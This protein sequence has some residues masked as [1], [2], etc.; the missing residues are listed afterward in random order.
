MLSFIR[1]RRRARQGKLVTEIGQAALGFS[2]GYQSL[3][4]APPPFKPRGR[5]HSTRFQEWL[6]Q[7]DGWAGIHHHG[8]TEYQAGRRRG[9]SS[10]DFRG[11]ESFPMNIIGHLRRQTDIQMRRWRSKAG[12]VR[13]LA[14]IAGR[15][16][17][18][19]HSVLHVNS[20]VNRVIGAGSQMPLPPNFRRQLYPACCVL[21]AVYACRAVFICLHYRYLLSPFGRDSDVIL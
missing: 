14:G 16:A 15:A 8:R 12:V 4:F 1:R 20:G 6:K 9:F 18:R 2:G 5:R 19:H 7:I 11:S 3:S 13:V 10:L 21:R 17:E